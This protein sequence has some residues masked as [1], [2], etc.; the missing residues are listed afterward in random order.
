HISG[1]HLHQHPDYLFHI[2]DRPPTYI[3]SKASSFV[4]LIT[5]IFF[6]I[7]LISGLIIGFVS[8]GT[9]LK[10]LQ[11]PDEPFDEN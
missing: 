10:V 2:L 9:R 11:L 3:K 8:V 5:G 7:A 4:S 6:L 1:G